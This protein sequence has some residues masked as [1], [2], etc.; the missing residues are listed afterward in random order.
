MKKILFL[1]FF[2]RDLRIRNDMF[3]IL[4][5]QKKNNIFLS[6]FNL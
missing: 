1:F 2:L 3:L 5:Y 4:N 6:N